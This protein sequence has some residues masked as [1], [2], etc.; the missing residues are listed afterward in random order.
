MN[1]PDAKKIYIVHGYKA[2]P[3]D[4][5][6]PWLSRKLQLAG[7]F[8]KRVM[9]AQSSQPDFEAWQK[10]LALQIPELDEDTIIVAHSLGC[11]AALHYLNQRFQA[12]GGSI[13]AGIFAA[14][15]KAP[16]PGAPELNSFIHQARLD[17]AML[18]HH[19]PLAFSLLSSND[20]LVPP[21]LTLQLGHFLNAQT[22]EVKQAGH[23]MR[24]DGYAEFHEVWE[25]IKPLLSA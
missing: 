9:L 22:Y 24:G 4:H 18:Q 11:L 16:L 20:P 23:F 21:P 1:S 19:M 7:H 5:W 12:A 25:L 3:N 10:F 13:K 15:F 14:G 2:S 6:F 17:S 8:S